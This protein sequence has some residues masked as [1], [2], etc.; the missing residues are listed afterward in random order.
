MIFSEEYY[1]DLIAKLGLPEMPIVKV[2][3]DVSVTVDAIKLR[4]DFMVMARRFVQF[5]AYNNLEQ[6][7]SAEMSMENIYQMRDGIVP[8]NISVYIKVPVEYGGKLEFSNMFLIKTRPFR[9]IL[10]KFIDEQVLTFNKGR[11]IRN[12]DAGIEM[13]SELFVPYPNGI[14]FVPALKGMAGAGGNATTDQMSQIGSTMFL[15][16]DGRF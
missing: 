12:M 3:K 7:A 13:P 14:V 8:E 1:R 5:V 2:T 6:I 16:N 11:E 15:K 9:G 4:M 10:D